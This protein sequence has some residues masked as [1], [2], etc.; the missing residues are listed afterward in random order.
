MKTNIT[1]FNIFFSYFNVE[2]D[3]KKD[4]YVPL[5]TT[6]TT[7]TTTTTPTTTINPDDLI[8]EGKFT[9]F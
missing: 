6:T 8:V 9:L 3:F 7:T 4:E 1:F 5:P 2:I